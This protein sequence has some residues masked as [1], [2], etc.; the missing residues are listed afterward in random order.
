MTATHLSPKRVVFTGGSGVAGRHVVSE[1][2]SYGHKILNIDLTPFDNKEVHTIRADLTQSSQ[3]FN[4]LSSHFKLT[5]P[6]TERLRALDAVIHFAG[7]PR[8]MLVTDDELF[9]INT[10]SAYNIIEAAAKLGIKKVILASSITVYV[11]TFAEGNIDYPSF[12]ID[13]EVDCN[14]MD[15]YAIS[16]LC[17]EAVA[18]SFARRFNIDV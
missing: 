3:A 13:E 12:P 8:N 16:K 11:V 9:R 7:V 4:C 17:V 6:F 5:Q 1:L 2:L 10:T 15:T 14:P 18:R